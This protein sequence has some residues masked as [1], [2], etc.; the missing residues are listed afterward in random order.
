MS[1]KVYDV[2]QCRAFLFFSFIQ[3]GNFA[4]AKVFVRLLQKQ[5]EEEE[6]EVGSNN[7]EQTTQR[8]SIALKEIAWAGVFMFS[9]CIN[10][11]LI[12]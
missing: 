11:L 9:R 4:A 8:R 6:R 2:M 12:N 3:K 5:L 7:K 1:N 10:V